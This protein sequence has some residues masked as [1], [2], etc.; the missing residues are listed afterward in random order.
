MRLLYN[1]AL[2]P[3]RL[4]LGPWAAWDSRRGESSR[5]EWQE[6][7]ARVL[8]EV[9]PGGLWLHGSSV[10]EA[11]IVAQLCDRLRE[12]SAGLPISVSAF[13]RSGRGLLPGPRR[14]DA[15]FFIPLDFPG[16]PARLLDAARP[17]VLALVETELWPN[18][19]HEALSRDVAV[20][21][22][23]GRLSRRRMSRYR[24][25]R[26]LYRP[27][28]AR[29]SRVGAQSAEDAR[30]FVELG[31][32]R[33]AVEVTGN[34]K[35]DLDPPPADAAAQRRRFGLPRTRPV[36]VAGSTAPGEDE[37]VLAAAARVRQ[38][39][40]ELFVVLA[41]RHVERS[42]DVRALAERAGFRLLPLSQARDAQ[43]AGY[44]GLLVDT[45]GELA[46]LYGMGLAGFV[47]GS[48]VPVGGHNVLEPPAAGTP[49]VFGPHTESFAGPAEALVRAGGAVRVHDAEGLADCWLELIADPGARRRMVEGAR[50]VIAAN[51]GALRRT[52]D[53]LL[54]LANGRGR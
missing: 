14:S 34:V 51:R 25:L 7:R 35:Y 6:R 47:G 18:L 12:C 37:P 41:P 43:A 8:P 42:E 53:L 46:A 22:V 54:A 38:R 20:A 39:H 15:A 36:V 49:A 32:R 10:G 17:R 23:N 28:L 2:L 29:L 50:S 30:R 26:G 1:T 3:L 9:R 31:V 33:E 24:R 40:P 48:L 19:L 16:L 27:L 52:V 44:D 5:R 11:R 45:I 4:L 13:T 21:V